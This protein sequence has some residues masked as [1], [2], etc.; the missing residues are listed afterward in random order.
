MLDLRSHDDL[1]DRDDGQVT[2]SMAAVIAGIVLNR[3]VGWVALQMGD[4]IGHSV[5][6]CMTK[7]VIEMIP[8]QRRGGIAAR[9]TAEH[10]RRIG[11]ELQLCRD[12]GEDGECDYGSHPISM[13]ESREWRK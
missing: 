1:V 4:S 11:D 8:V 12:Q 5:S 6:D 13:R 7:V 9:T 2:G 10:L 3:I